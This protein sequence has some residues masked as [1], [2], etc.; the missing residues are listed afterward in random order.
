MHGAAE[1][2]RYVSE[3]PLRPKLLYLFCKRSLL[4][5]ILQM[6]SIHRDRVNIGTVSSPAGKLTVISVF[7]LKAASFQMAL[8]RGFF[9][10]TPLILI[11]IFIWNVVWYFEGVSFV[12]AVVSQP[13]PRLIE[14]DRWLFVVGFSFA[15]LSNIHELYSPDISSS[16]S[17][18]QLWLLKVFLEIATCPLGATLS[19]CWEPSVVVHPYTLNRNSLG[20]MK[21][22]WNILDNS[23]EFFFWGGYQ[24][25]KEDPQISLSFTLPR[26]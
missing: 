18:R 23:V 19:S 9:G 1:M 14:W 12:F 24:I 7:S 26:W 20:I 15:L 17:R 10:I 13:Q 8:W 2:R 5:A 6:Y 21:L 3:L 22:C 4:F 11:T 16:P 25:L